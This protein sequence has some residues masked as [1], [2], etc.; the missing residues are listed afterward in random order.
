MNS[1]G[2]NPLPN[3]QLDLRENLMIP[4]D[5]NLSSEQ[6]FKPINL[7]LQ[8]NVQFPKQNFS[9]NSYVT[10]VSTSTTVSLNSHSWPS[11][12]LPNHGRPG[13]QPATHNTFSTTYSPT[14]SRPIQLSP[15]PTTGMGLQLLHNDRPDPYR[16]P[17]TG[18]DHGL[19]AIHSQHHRSRSPLSTS[20]DDNSNITSV[21]SRGSN[22]HSDRYCTSLGRQR[23]SDEASVGH[24]AAEWLRGFG[25]Y[26]S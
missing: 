5:I 22:S 15:I 25:W 4:S 9:N 10:K 17:S 1:G 18:P 21:R 24:R 11:E 2:V 6:P 26:A 23:N 14:F 8:P 13:K 19:S 3:R 20:F 7:N 16:I 12:N